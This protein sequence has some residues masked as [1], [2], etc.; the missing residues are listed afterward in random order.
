MKDL[1][2][3]TIDLLKD[4]VKVN[5]EEIK[6]NQA[7]IR[8][9]LKENP[10]GNRDPEFNQIY[11][12][13]KVLLSENNDFIN[14][15]INLVNFLNKYKDTPVLQS[16]EEVEHEFDE[17]VDYF[18]LTIRGI[19]KFDEKHPHFHD[20]EFFEK[21]LE[22]YQEREDYETCKVLVDSRG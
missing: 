19:V 3:K 21:L 16:G 4:K 12:Q 18:A 15:Q 22:Y 2:Q 13:N 7:L 1:V 6:T 5:L 17:N 11:N 9:M 10:Q 20:Q 14:L 8:D